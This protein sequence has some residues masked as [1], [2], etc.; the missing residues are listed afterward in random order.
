[1]EQRLQ[2]MMERLFV[3]QTQELREM[4]GKILAVQKEIMAFFRGSR[5]CENGTTVSLRED[6]VSTELEIRPG[7]DGGRTG[8]SGT[9]NGRSQRRKLRVIGCQIWGTMFGC[10][11]SP[12]GEEAAPRQCGSRQKLSA[13]RKRQ[14]RCVVPTMCKGRVRKG[15]GNVKAAKKVPNSK[16]LVKSRRMY[17]SGTW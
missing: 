2:E 16:T 17:H 11:A 10:V 4:K 14:I 13:A 9:P 3:R 5:T 8:V 6:V 7:C 15:P 1:M 12:R